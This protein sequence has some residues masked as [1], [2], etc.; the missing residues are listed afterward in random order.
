MEKCLVVLTPGFPSD[1]YDTTCVPAVQNFVRA[2]CKIYPGRNI[3]VIAFQYPFE[4]KIY[5]WNGVEVIALGGKNRAGFLRVITWIKAYKT[6]K[7]ICKS[8]RHIALLSFWMTECALI[9]KH[10]GRKKQLGH[11]TWLQ[12]QDALKTNRYVKRIRP[13]AE[14]VVAIS[15][16]NQRVFFEN[17]GVMPAHVIEN[18]VIE[19]QFPELNT[20][21]RQIDILGVGSLTEGKNYAL[22]L[23]I[24][25]KLQVKYP[26]LTCVIAGDGPLTAT[27]KKQAEKLGLRNIR[28]TDLIAHSQV[29]ELMN[30]SRI[31]L[32]TSGYEGSSSA[33]IEA[34]YSGCKVVARQPL[35]DH[36][37]KNLYVADSQNELIK[38]TEKLLSLSE[39]PERVLFNSMEDSAKK[40]IELL[41]D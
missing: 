36:I 4:E 25:A 27:L 9:G 10:F 16:T 21:E 1:E 23:E 11:I 13:A 7:K 29:L 18:G 15:C 28:F 6:L 2:A 35:S 38:I 33:M 17:H 34:L 19:K 24:A 32:H 14:S 3:L 41:N 39:K 31:F 37:V 22:F 8:Y 26:R 30:N 20:S 5:H 40:I 12:G